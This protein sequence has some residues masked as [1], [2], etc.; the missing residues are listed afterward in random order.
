MLFAKPVPDVVNNEDYREV[1]NDIDG[2]LITMYRVARE[3]PQEF[4]R[5][6][7]HTPYSQAEHQRA[8]AIL[9]DIGDRKDIE[10]AWAYLVKISQSFQ[11]DLSAGWRT[12]INSK[13][14]AYWWNRHI[15]R[16]PQILDRL[17]HVFISQEDAIACID[18]WD[19][20]QTL[21]YVDPPYVNA[22]QG[23]YKGFTQEDFE[24]LVDKLKSIQ[25]SFVLS[26]YDNPYPPSD[27]E[28]HEIVVWCASDLRGRTRKLNVLPDASERQRTEIIWVCDRSRNIRSDLQHLIQRTQLNL[29]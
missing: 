27:W 12:S 26:N 25:G 24:R 4:Y 23:H 6:C 7:R 1:I 13:H 29:F 9:A 5:W 3:R 14:L 20:P 2:R 11:N 10:I 16:L 15:E 18:R 17:R 8:A 19:S 22:H 28:K 21:F